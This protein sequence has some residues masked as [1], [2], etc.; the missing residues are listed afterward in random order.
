MYASTNLYFLS[1][2][3]VIT[4]MSD[5][6][7]NS[8]LINQMTI[9]CLFFFFL[10][11]VF[12]LPAIFSY[13]ADKDFRRRV[14]TRPINLHTYQRHERYLQA[15]ARA[16]TASPPSAVTRCTCVS[17]TRSR[18]AKSLL[19]NFYLLVFLHYLWQAHRLPKERCTF[20]VPEPS[21]QAKGQC[22]SVID[23]QFDGGYREKQ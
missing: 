9:N 21:R 12:L 13:Y 8:D 23:K 20:A 6:I 4:I 10:P 19:A 15:A 18:G 17:F 7:R 5:I 22:P 11:S 1:R 16:F 2:S 14:F 3:Y